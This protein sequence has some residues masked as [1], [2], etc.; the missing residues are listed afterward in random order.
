[1]TLSKEGSF[2]VTELVL[3]AEQSGVMDAIRTW[4]LDGGETLT[5]GGYAGV[6]KTTILGKLQRLLPEAKRIV[7]CSYTGKAVSVLKSKLPP[8]TEI[9]TLHRLLYKPRQQPYCIDSEEPAFTRLGTEG[10]WCQLHEANDDACECVLRLDWSPNPY[11]L[12]G[13]DLVVV[14]EASMVDEKIWTDLTRHGV[15]VLAVGDHG[16]LPPIRGSFNLMGAPQLRL[17]KVLRQAE[18]SPIIKMS[19]LART[20]GKIPIGDYG[21]NCLKVA[22]YK[23]SQM[24]KKLKPKNGDIAICAMNRTRVDLNDALRT[25]PRGAAP[26]VGDI[27]ICLRN[28]YENG[29]FNGQRG[30]ITEFTNP[31]DD[32]YEVFRSPRYFAGIQM[33]D[34]DYEYRGFI[35]SEQFREQK[36]QSQTLRSLGLWD[37][38]YAMTCHKAQG[39]Q[40]DRVLVVEEVMREGEHAR[41]LYTAVTRA[42]RSLCIVGPA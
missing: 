32:G 8:G 3:T 15:P 18:G 28:S 37:Y 25:Q 42:A 40:A 35:S 13:I 2:R 39:S 23:R 31:E 27:V 14:D 30:R 24:V 36:T 6:G 7:F 38:G 5:L 21:Q 19:I 9:S 41:W 26:V 22:P 16:Q 34:D 11:P 29:V 10:K 20:T 1:V 4:F 17:E 33:L 12:D